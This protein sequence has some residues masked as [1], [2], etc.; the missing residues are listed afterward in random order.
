MAIRVTRATRLPIPTSRLS[1]LLRLKVKKVIPEHRDQKEIL[2]QL[3]RLG[4]KGLREIKAI[5]V[6]RDRR[7]NKARRAILGQRETQVL[8]EQ[9][10]QMQR[11]PERQLP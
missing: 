1:S 2:V 8:P 6:H 9:L 4:L 11:L 3:E 5:Q 10:A 7:A